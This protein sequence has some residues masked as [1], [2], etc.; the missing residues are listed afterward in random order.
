MAGRSSTI[1]TE[2]STRVVCTSHAVSGAKS[3]SS[4][5]GYCESHEMDAPRETIPC[6]S[7][8]STRPLERRA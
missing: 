7:S 5:E 8:K 4:S 3:T 2:P 1:S 6:C